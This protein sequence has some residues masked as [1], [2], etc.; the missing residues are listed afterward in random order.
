MG[1]AKIVNEASGVPDRYRTRVGV[2]VAY[3]S[4][5]DQVMEVLLEIG[6]G[7]QKVRETPEARVRFRAFGE[8]S[9]DFELL[10]WIERPADRGLVTHELNCEVYRAF[11]EAGISIPFPQRDLYIKEMP[12]D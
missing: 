3:G 5:I 10:C 9:L 7:H 8:S 1:A 2:G 12:A 11:A 4:D 6:K